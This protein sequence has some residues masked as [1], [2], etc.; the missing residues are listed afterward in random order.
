[1]N[2]VQYLNETEGLREVDRTVSA[3]A[4]S[5]ND[6]GVLKYTTFFPIQNVDTTE[7]EDIIIGTY[8][9]TASRREWN[10]PGR[11]IPVKTPDIRNVNI[12]PV[13]SYFTV[14]EQEMQKLE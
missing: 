8:R 7:I 6:N 13:E 4:V 1:M 2:V 9:P 3:Q 5:P 11:L 14:G 10:G 12:I